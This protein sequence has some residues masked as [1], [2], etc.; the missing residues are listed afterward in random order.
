MEGAHHICI[1]C[2]SQIQQLHTALMCGECNRWQH[3]R[4][5]TGIS[6][7]FYWKVAECLGVFEWSCSACRTTQSEGNE[8]SQ[9][10]PQPKRR[11]YSIDGDGH[12][13][14]PAPSQHTAP[15][16]S[17]PVAPEPVTPGPALPGKLPQESILPE[18][19]LPKSI[20]PRPDNAVLVLPEPVFPEPAL[21]D[22]T[23]PASTSDD[24]PMISD[25]RSDLGS[26]EPTQPTC[27]IRMLDNSS[28]QGHQPGS[29]P[30]PATCV[31]ISDSSS[32]VPDSDGGIDNSSGDLP[33]DIFTKEPITY[34][35][36]EKGSKQ[37]KQLLMSSDGYSFRIKMYGAKSNRWQCSLPSCRAA[38]N[39]RGDM[40]LPSE[41]DHNHLPQPYLRLKR[42]MIAEAKSR[43][44]ADVNESAESIA[45]EICSKVQEKAKNVPQGSDIIQIV[46]NTRRRMER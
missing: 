27:A 7:D 9:I 4:C 18:T 5:G 42:E 10:S 31:L 21:L 22:L 39:Q 19:I 11:C 38:V 41:A 30:K 29:S 15:V 1:A 28:A 13:T 46:N 25:S 43:A 20:P 26:P 44:V 37:G 24:S 45:M 34:D 33:M 14:I 3:L 17:Q 16:H 32:D 36:L 23:G 8:T 12:P 6:Q 40:F 2:S 35:I